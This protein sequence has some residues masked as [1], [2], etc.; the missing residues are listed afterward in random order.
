MNK[1]KEILETIDVSTN[2]EKI[3]DENDYIDDNF[4]GFLYGIVTWDSE[5]RRWIRKR[6]N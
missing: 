5:K 3:N 1:E 4:D 6:F 2:D